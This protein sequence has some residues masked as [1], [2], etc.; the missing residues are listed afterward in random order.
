MDT[1]TEQRMKVLRFIRQYRIDYGYSP[2]VRDI[3]TATGTTLTPAQYHVNAL[4]KA[5]ML[6]RTDGLSRTLRLTEAGMEALNEN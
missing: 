6:Q 2:A 4:V 1:L 5:E 3:A